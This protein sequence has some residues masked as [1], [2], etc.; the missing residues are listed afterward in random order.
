MGKMKFQLIL[1]VMQQGDLQY[2][3]RGHSGKAKVSWDKAKTL[4]FD[5]TF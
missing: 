5:I 2:I 1:Q 4:S 3:W